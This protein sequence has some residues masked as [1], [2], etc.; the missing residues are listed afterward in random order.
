MANSCV[1]WAGCAGS[2]GTRTGKTT[3]WLPARPLSFADRLSAP[4]VA[5]SRARSSAND[6]VL[7]GPQHG[8]GPGR[9]APL[10]ISKQGHTEDVRPFLTEAA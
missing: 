5:R 9:P 2:I 3:T 6:G 10:P 7:H 1:G 4:E 8:G